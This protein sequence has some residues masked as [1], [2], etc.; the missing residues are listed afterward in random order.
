MNGVTSPLDAD[1][2]R[3]LGQ[4]RA[5]SKKLRVA[6]IVALS[7]VITLAF[8]GVLSLLF[9]LIGASIPLVSLALLAL[10][11]NEER[12]RRRL[13]A[14]DSRAPLQLAINQLALFALVFAYCAWSAYGTWFGP[15]PLAALT[16]QSAEI[17]DAIDQLNQQMDGVS[18][19]SSWARTAALVIYAAVLLGSALVQGLTALYYR[20]LRVHVEALARAPEWARAL[21]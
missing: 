4:T 6:R 7:N 20:A 12:G 2:L 8:L 11:Y 19:L 1:Q 15:D 3:V 13:A 16:S 5:L 10:A 9:D 17:S 21:D 18:E 14:L